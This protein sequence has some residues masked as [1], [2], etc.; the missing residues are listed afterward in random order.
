MGVETAIALASIAGGVTSS[1]L[2]SR[3][4][5]ATN[6]PVYTPGQEYLQGKTGDILSHRLDNPTSQ[7]E[8]LKTSAFHGVNKTYNGLHERLNE[9]LASRG[10]E[11]SGQ[12]VS[13]AREI[14]V[15]RAGALGGLETKFA[16]LELDQQNR[17]LEQALRFAF[18]QPGS[19]VTTPGNSLGAALG[20]GTA[21][22]TQWFLLQQM[23]RN[24]G[25]GSS[26]PQINT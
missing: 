3:K 8:P 13:G 7:V 11:K 16:G 6:A 17:L 25:S 26:V 18:A 24:P 22:L 10:L 20:A 12:A 19:A 4:R 23:L 9:T 1:A 15:E 14:E 5:T 21:D 2:S